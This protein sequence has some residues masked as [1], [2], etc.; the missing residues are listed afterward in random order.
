MFDIKIKKFIYLFIYIIIYLFT[1]LL[2]FYLFIYFG[3]K[4]QI[5]QG[6]LEYLE[7]CGC[8]EAKT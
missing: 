5:I 4:L 6:N 2:V 1:Y 8:V 7:K 3:R